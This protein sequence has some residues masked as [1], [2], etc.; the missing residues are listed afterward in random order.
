LVYGI[1]RWNRRLT[2][3][4]DRHNGTAA[5]VHRNAYGLSERIDR[6]CRDELIAASFLRS[7][8][9]QDEISANE[10]FKEST[11]A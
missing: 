10:R 11:V 5:L 7:S 2:R 8:A 6:R 1:A 3:Q 9:K 4:K